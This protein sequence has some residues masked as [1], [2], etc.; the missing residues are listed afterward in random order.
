[1]ISLSP[2]TAL[3]LYLSLTLAIL[4]AI[5]TFNHYR[6]RQKKIILAEEHLLVCE[7][8]HFAYLAQSEKK[9]TQCPQCNSFNKNNTYQR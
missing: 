9:V 4:F 1:M 3:M 6:T 8:C 7:Y 2:N 5:W